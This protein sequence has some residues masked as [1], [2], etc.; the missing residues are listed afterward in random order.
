MLKNIKDMLKPNGQLLFNVFDFT[1]LD[2]PYEKLD[3][4]KWRK[5]NN[6]NSNSPFYK[7]E[8]PMKE[9]ETLIKSFGFD[10]CHFHLEP[11]V[12]QV[13]EDIFDGK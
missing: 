9:Y 2:E 3:K 10:D 4:G 11:L 13:P 12:F 6:R 8:N 1:V 5:Y 7:C